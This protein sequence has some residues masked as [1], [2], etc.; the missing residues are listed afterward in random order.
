M[1]KTGKCTGFMVAQGPVRIL[2]VS[3][4]NL[5]DKEPP[6]DQVVLPVNQ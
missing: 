1:C 2:P 6:P 4:F 3:L 5:P